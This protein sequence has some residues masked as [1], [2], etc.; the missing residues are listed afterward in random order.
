MQLFAQIRRDARV[1]GLGIRALARKY[2]VGRDTVRQALASPEPPA[3]KTPVRRAPKLE[4]WSRSSTACCDKI[5]MRRGSRC[6]PRRGSGTGSST[7]TALTCPT[8]SSGTTAAGKRRVDGFVP[9]AHLPAAEGEVDFGEVWVVIAG[10]RTKCYMFAFR[11]SHSGKAG[12]GD[13]VAAVLRR[14]VVSA[15]GGGRV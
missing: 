11:L 12:L 14:V 7:S 9:Q 13:Q 6:R 1:E 15:S 2:R 3:R 8:A 4:R 5:W 10:V